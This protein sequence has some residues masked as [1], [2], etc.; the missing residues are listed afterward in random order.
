[1]RSASF[2]GRPQAMAGRDSFRPGCIT[3][4]AA[5]DS[6]VF[7]SAWALDKRRTQHTHSLTLTLLAAELCWVETWPTDLMG[8][9]IDSYTLSLSLFP[10]PT[11]TITKPYPVAFECLYK[12]PVSSHSSLRTEG[13]GGITRVCSDPMR[14]HTQSHNK[15]PHRILL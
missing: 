2:Q 1:M 10:S 8:C 6:G 13:A 15:P 7:G 5:L 14:E 9:L 4:Q 12:A 3:R 11:Y